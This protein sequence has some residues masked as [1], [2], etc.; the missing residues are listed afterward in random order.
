MAAFAGEFVISFGLMIMVLW[1]SNTSRLSRHVGVL[2]GLLLALYIT[3][4]A[5]LS[6]MSIN[7]ARTFASALPA[8]LWTAFWLYLTAPILAMQL[9]AQLYLF[10]RGRRQVYCAKL[11]HHS[12]QPCIFRCRFEELEKGNQR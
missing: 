2:A 4:E 8:G 6:G 7:P 9:A 3:F 11:N 10:T 5:P 12:R 1:A